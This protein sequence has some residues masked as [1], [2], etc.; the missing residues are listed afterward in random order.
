MAETNN[1]YACDLVH[2]LA[3][4]M[5]EREMAGNDEVIYVC[6]RSLVKNLAIDANGDIKAADFVTAVDGKLYR[7]DMVPDTVEGTNA[8][9]ND[10]ACGSATLTARTDR[11]EQKMRVFDRVARFK[12]LAYFVAGVG[13]PFVRAY[14]SKWKKNKYASQFTTGK[15]DTDEHGFTITITVPATD[16]AYFRIDMKGATKQ[17]EEM[18]Y[19][20]PSRGEEAGSV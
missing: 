3:D 19:T 7:I 1:T 20:E 15:T 18:V 10:N 13:K 17:L 4:S 8:V 11:D 2:V 5:C 6:E 14:F 12:D 16:F 9:E